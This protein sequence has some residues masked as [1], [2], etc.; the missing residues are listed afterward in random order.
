M[1]I[2][3]TGRTFLKAA[4]LGVRVVTC[5]GEAQTIAETLTARGRAGEVRRAQKVTALE[6][7]Q[8]VS[9]W[10]RCRSWTE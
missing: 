8:A 1:K 7:Y 5:G 10:S 6:G 9:S 2:S 3:L 4:G